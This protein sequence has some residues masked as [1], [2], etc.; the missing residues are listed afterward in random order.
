MRRLV[1]GSLAKVSLVG[2]VCFALQAPAQQPAAPATAAAAPTIQL[3]PLVVVEGKRPGEVDLAVDI[4]STGKVVHTSLLSGDPKLFG[5]AAK[6][7]S[8][9]LYRDHAGVTGAKAHVSFLIKKD[10]HNPTPDYPPSA[11]AAHV[12]GTVEL[13][14]E[15]E[16]DGHVTRITV[17]SGPPM[18]IGSATDAFQRWVFP[19]I[20]P[21]ASPVQPR[22]LVSFDYDLW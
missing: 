4:D 7:V 17:V 21:S 19:A 18:L 6:A 15:I 16:P 12:S 1:L 5:S 3:V 22:V 13:A 11:R 10:L 8:T 20:Q 14:G 9:F 2:V